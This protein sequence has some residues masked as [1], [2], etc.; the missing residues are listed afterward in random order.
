MMSFKPQYRLWSKTTLYT[1]ELIS[2][3][4]C[5]TLGEAWGATANSIPIVDSDTGTV[6]CLDAGC[7]GIKRECRDARDLDA[8]TSD[9]HCGSVLQLY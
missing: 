5:T 2:H 8:Q 7:L 4:D 3:V 1:N 9:Q 6:V